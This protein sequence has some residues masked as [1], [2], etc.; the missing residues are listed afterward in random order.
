MYLSGPF[1]SF[2]LEYII[3]PFGWVINLKPR[4]VISYELRKQFFEENGDIILDRGFGQ[5]RFREL[6][7]IR[8]NLDGTL[9]NDIEWE[10]EISIQVKCPPIIKPCGVKS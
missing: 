1:I 4:K 7:K 2:C 3:K 9:C 5:S 10:H 6:A 8:H